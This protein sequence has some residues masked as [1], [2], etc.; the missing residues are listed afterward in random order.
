[1][2]AKNGLT[3]IAYPGV[4]DLQLRRHHTTDDIGTSPAATMI[5]VRG[6][7]DIGTAAPSRTDGNGTVIHP[8]ADDNGTTPKSNLP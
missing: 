5:L 1:M 2:P 8:V 4:A 7:A 6:P 3:S